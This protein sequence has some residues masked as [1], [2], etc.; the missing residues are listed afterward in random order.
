MYLSLYLKYL[1]Q[2][3]NDVW[4]LSTVEHEHYNIILDV[5]LY[6]II[7]SGR[8][9]GCMSDNVLVEKTT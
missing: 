7:N 9:V 5:L 8:P 4:V 3:K 6:R 2:Q 1:S